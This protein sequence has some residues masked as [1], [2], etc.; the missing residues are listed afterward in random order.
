MKY[1]PG[2]LFLLLLFS[3]TRPVFTPDTNTLSFKDLLNAVSEHQQRITSIE[4]Q[5][6]ITVESPDF[7]GSFSATVLISKPDSM[8]LKASGPFGIRLGTLFVGA[9]RFVFYNQMANKFMSG[10]VIDFKD[11]T[12]FQFPLNL[13]QLVDIFSAFDRIPNMKVEE[14]RIVDD[15]FY[16]AGTDNKKDYRIHIDPRSGRISK[17]EVL[18]NDNVIVKKEYKDFERS[19]DVWFAKRAQ[20]VLPQSKQGMSLYFS[21]YK[22]NKKLEPGQFEITISDQA[23]QIKTFLP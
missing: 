12:F 13:S 22:L 9:D 23:D 18:E 4:G 21:K 5:C 11:R 2:L 19:G 20:I 3:C 17:F 10:S 16:I 14:Y 15:Q 8:L 6:S 7:S 1:I